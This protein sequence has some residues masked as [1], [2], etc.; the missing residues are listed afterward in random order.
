MPWPKLKGSLRKKP[1]AAQPEDRYPS[2]RKR[3]PPSRSIATGSGV[4]RE[5]HKL[6]IVYS[7]K[8]PSNRGV[9]RQLSQADFADLCTWS[10]RTCAQYLQ[11]RGVFGTKEHRKCW[12]RRSKMAPTS[13]PDVL[14]CTWRSPGSQPRLHNPKYSHTPFGGRLRGGHPMDHAGFLRCCYVAALRTPQDSAWHL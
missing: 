6:G 13:D 12:V 11:K 1:A 7:H 4:N 9:L 3:L 8:T 2:G 10:E 14:R 5:H